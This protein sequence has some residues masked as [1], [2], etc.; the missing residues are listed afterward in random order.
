MFIIPSVFMISILYLIKYHCTRPET[1]VKI[2]VSC[3]P[4][5]FVAVSFMILRKQLNL[6]AAEI[7]QTGTI[8]D[9]DSI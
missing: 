2:V 8:S 3:A 4:F 9:W 7:G 1:I 5:L 6:P